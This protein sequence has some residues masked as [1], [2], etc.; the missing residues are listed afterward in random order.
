MIR[1]FERSAKSGWGNRLNIV[2]H[3]NRVVGFDYDKDCCETFGYR[4]WSHDGVDITATTGDTIDGAVF[5]PNEPATPAV[6]VH[7]A[8]VY[9]DLD[10]GDRVFFRVLFPDGRDPIFLEL[11]NS[12][13]GYY[14]HGFEFLINGEVKRKGVL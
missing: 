4:W 2:D 3:Q 14:G 12:H 9:D 13:N 7:A 6:V 5:D 8:D 10:A 11:Y 1:V